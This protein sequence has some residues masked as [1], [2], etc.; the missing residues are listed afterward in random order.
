MEKLFYT[1]LFTICMHAVFSQCSITFG[2]P[3]ITNEVCHG[4]NT[5]SIRVHAMAKDNEQLS[6]K[7]NTGATGD[8]IDNLIAAAYGVTVS[9]YL[10]CSASAAFGINQPAAITPNIAVTD[11]TSNG[12][13]NGTLSLDANGG[14]PPYIFSLNRIRFQQSQVIQNLSA[15]SYAIAVT[16]AN[17][18]KA[19][20]GVNVKEPAAIVADDIISGTACDENKNNLSASATIDGEENGIYSL[21]NHL[22]LDADIY[23]NPYTGEFRL[24]IASSDND[25]IHI[26]IFDINGRPVEERTYKA[27]EGQ[28]MLGASC[29]SGIYIIK[30]RQGDL[31]RQLRVVK[32][33]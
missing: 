4:G 25:D 12:V 1:I 20:A 28:V 24:K 7:W 9:D 23:P 22:S 10:G 3:E 19:V 21:T 17:G 15:G 30:I 6:Y 31:S 14:R 29:I 26:T 32:V 13:C 33:D 8:R 11:V 18:C 16:D 2:L 27:S 5:A